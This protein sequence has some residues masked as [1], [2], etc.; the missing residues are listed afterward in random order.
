MT[1]WST[2]SSLI[3]YKQRTHTNTHTPHTH[4]Q[5]HTHFQLTIN[6]KRRQ[7][8]GQQFLF[9]RPM[10]TRKNEQQ[11]DIYIYPYLY[12]HMTGGGGLMLWGEVG[13]SKGVLRYLKVASANLSPRWACVKDC[14]V[15][16]KQLRSLK[17]D[18]AIDN[19][20]SIGDTIT[21]S[22]KNVFP[23]QYLLLK[24]LGCLKRHKSAIY[25]SITSY[26]LTIR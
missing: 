10:V 5:P 24:L 12:M 2:C 15:V 7:K 8:S 20:L 16:F 4:T 19:W 9:F 26:R 11:K 22:D 17:C 14:H 23:F 13:G 25:L 18:I 1:I 21:I 3:N 6:E